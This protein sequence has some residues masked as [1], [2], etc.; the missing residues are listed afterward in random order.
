M[1]VR[2]AR[3]RAAETPSLARSAAR[4]SLVTLVAQAVRIG[5]QFVSIFVLARLLDSV[6]YGYLAMVLAIIGVA[7]LVRDFG[8]SA[9]AVQ[10]R[11]LSNAQQS[12]LFWLNS[13][14]GLVSSVLVLAVSP[15]IALLYGEPALTPITL[16]LAPIFLLNG[17]ATQF[18]AR[19]NRDL[20]FVALAAADVL[21]QVAAFAVAI[22]TLR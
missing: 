2:G 21:P 19:M 15:L 14:I 8:L 1:S 18:R 13:L 17:I 3:P 22:S 4:G 7:E 6:D 5:T 16:A 11:S 10:S 9:A 12:N 20:R